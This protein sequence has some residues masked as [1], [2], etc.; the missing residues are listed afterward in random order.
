MSITSWNF[1]GLLA[2]QIDAFL[3]RLDSERR[4]PA[5]SDHQSEDVRDR[6]YRHGRC[7]VCNK[8]P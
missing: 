7:F 3:L 5:K 6:V 4:S 2:R 8:N 1:R